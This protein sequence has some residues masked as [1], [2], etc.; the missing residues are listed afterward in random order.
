M[1]PL[2]IILV[3]PGM[4]SRGA[5]FSDLS[6]SLSTRYTTAVIQAGGAPMILPPTIEPRV[7]ARCVAR[8]DGVMLTGGDDV[9]PELYTLRLPRG[10][11]ETIAVTPDGGHRDLRELR[12]LD[13]VFRQRKP[14]LAICRGHQL[15]N[16]ALGGTLIPDLPRLQPGPIRHGRL[17]A[18]GEPVHDV[19]LTEDSLIARIVGSQTLSVNSTHHQAVG[20]VARPLRVTARSVDGIVEG[21]ELNPDGAHWL[22]FLLSVQFHPERLVNR[23]AQ[24][25]SIFRALVQSAD[26]SRAYL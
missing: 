11:R 17:D 10:V 3:T 13:E 5:E 24:H 12:V 6:I 4:E 23:S 8:A 1:K 19:H 21:L 20:R 22:P 15:L 9:Q 16:V 25:A 26:L 7:I 18:P 14:L 2:P